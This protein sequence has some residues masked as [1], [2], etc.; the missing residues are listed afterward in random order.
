MTKSETSLTKKITDNLM[1]FLVGLLLTICTW[2]G[3]SVIDHEK[4]VTTI[5]ASKYTREDALRDRLR[6]REWL[7]SALQKIQIA[8]TR[9]RIQVSALE[10]NLTRGRHFRERPK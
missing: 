3:S 4:R 10:A 6:G 8:I 9:L 7:T 1:K 5:E 2:L